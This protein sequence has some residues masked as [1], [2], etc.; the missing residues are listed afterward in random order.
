M[1]GTTVA[2]AVAVSASAAAAAS[3]AV[4][5]ARAAAGAARRSRPCTGDRLRGWD[6]WWPRLPRC[7]PQGSW[8][9]SLG[10]SRT[11]RFVSQRQRSRRRGG[12][13]RP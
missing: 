7:S 13:R 8:M 11:H 2:M 5:A 3:A 9:S 10:S 12:H 4:A 1:A 6:P